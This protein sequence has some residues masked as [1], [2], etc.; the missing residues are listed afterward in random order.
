[1]AAVARKSR[2]S[3][4][5]SNASLIALNEHERWALLVAMPNGNKCYC[6]TKPF[7][8][9]LSELLVKS[10]KVGVIDWFTGMSHNERTRLNDSAMVNEVE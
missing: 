6:T 3:S 2:D 10:F 1:M 9:P 5:A 8:M 4:S 7:C